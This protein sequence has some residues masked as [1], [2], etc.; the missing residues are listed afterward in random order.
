MRFIYSTILKGLFTLLPIALT[1][2]LLF[3]IATSVE[4]LFGEPIRLYLPGLTYF[5]GVGVIV[6]LALAFLAGL[7][8][9]HYFTKRFFHWFEKR[10]ENLPVIKTIYMPLRDMTKLFA[11]SSGGPAAQ[12]VV[13]V[14]MSETGLEALG[15]VTREGFHDLPEGTVGSDSLAVFIPFS[16][17]VG[18][19]TIVVPKSEVRETSLPAEKALQLAITG[20]I[21][22]QG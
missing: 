12:K 5:P 20:W 21:K 2:F 16:Y 10:L 18:G 8:V 15:L 3:W 6:V 9:D 17:G 14:K 1:L 4:S 19:V 11:K 13:M 7:L 22:S